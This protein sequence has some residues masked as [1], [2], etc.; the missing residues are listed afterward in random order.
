[1][2]TT[3]DTRPYATYGDIGMGTFGNSQTQNPTPSPLFSETG[4][5]ALPTWVPTSRWLRTLSRP[6]ASSIKP[7]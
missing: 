5:L 7:T 2:T 6:S 1:M 3:S 4:P